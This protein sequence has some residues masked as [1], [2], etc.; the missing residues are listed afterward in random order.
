M[1]VSVLEMSKWHLKGCGYR[2]FIKM[3]FMN[4]FE[5]FTMIYFALDAFYGTK[6]EDVFIMHSY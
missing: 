4:E 3:I 2:Y 6:I 1:A 5:L